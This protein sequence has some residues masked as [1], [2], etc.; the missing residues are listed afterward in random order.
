MQKIW[1]ST[2]AGLNVAV[3]ARHATAVELCLYDDE[4]KVET[5]RIRLPAC[6]GGVWHGF[7]PGPGAGQRYGLRA[8]GPWD[9]PAGHR[10]E[11]PGIAGCAARAAW[12]RMPRARCS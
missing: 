6:T 3:Y 1:A 2:S 12:A 10:R 4:G 9:P 7:V 5:A 11:L 8:H